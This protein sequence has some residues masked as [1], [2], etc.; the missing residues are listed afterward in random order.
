MTSTSFFHLKVLQW[1]LKITLLYIWVE[2]SNF[3]P[4]LLK[5]LR[6][7][8]FHL[9]MQGPRPRPW[10]SAIY[11][12]MDTTIV[13]WRIIPVL[14][15]RLLPEQSVELDFF[16]FFV[17]FNDCSI[18]KIGTLETTQVCRGYRPKRK[19]PVLWARLPPKQSVELDFCTFL[20]CSIIVQQ[21][22][23]RALDFF[24]SI[25]NFDWFI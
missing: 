17:V 14:W 23:P 25:L 15:A 16:Y 24:L 10:K 9:G 3:K 21:K 4:C 12:K 7:Y 20:L 6:A 5:R 13:F 19:I 2:W 11:R 1:P 8:T 18:K 22:K